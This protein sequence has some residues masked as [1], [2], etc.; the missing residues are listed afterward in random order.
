MAKSTKKTP[1]VRW[2]NYQL[3]NYV[4]DNGEEGFMAAE[5]Y[6]IQEGK[7]KEPRIWYYQPV[8]VAGHTLEEVLAVL[9]EIQK[10]ITELD[11]PIVTEDQLPDEDKMEK[12]YD[13]FVAE[14][15]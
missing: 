11:L 3:I 13:R 7:K 6:W 5:V 14:N 15:S 8:T 10:S 2:W 12:E 9:D 4:D 1:S